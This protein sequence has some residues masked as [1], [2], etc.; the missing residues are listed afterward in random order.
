[1]SFQKEYFKSLTRLSRELGKTDDQDKMLQLIVTMAAETLKAKALSFFS[2]K[3]T[4]R[5]LFAMLLLFRL[6]SLKNISMRERL[7]P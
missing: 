5:S 1:M 2:M 3:K 4:R 7:M 6:D